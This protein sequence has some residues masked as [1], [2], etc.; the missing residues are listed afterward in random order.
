MAKRPL[1]TRTLTAEKCE[2]HSKLTSWPNHDA[3]SWATQD[4]AF[5]KPPESPCKSECRSWGFGFQG[6]GAGRNPRADDISETD[7]DP[8]A[9]GTP[10]PQDGDLEWSTCPT[11]GKCGHLPRRTVNE[12]HEQIRPWKKKGKKSFFRNAAASVEGKKSMR[13]LVNLSKSFR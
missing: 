2:K 1:K 4:I 8:R 5:P 11:R 7:S 13:L 3:Q 6:G 9:P 12:S 10:W